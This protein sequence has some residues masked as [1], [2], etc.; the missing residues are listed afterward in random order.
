MKAKKLISTITSFIL[1]ALVITLAAIFIS[2]KMTGGDP[3]FFGYQLK[4]V[5]SGSMEPEFDRGSIIAVKPGGDM[6]RFEKDDIITF[7][8]DEKTYITHRVLEV[9]KDGNQVFY[10]TKGDN[11]EDPDSSHVLSG[12]VV[13]EYTGFTVP[14][15]GY[16]VNFAKSKMGTAA[17]LFIPGILL[18]I[19]A[20]HLINSALSDI[21]NQKK[22]KT[23]Q[24]KIDV[25]NYEDT[26]SELKVERKS[27]TSFRNKNYSGI[28]RGK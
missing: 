18:I 20:I 3:T 6:T 9:K 15:I 4:A 1:I 22:I 19:Y 2:S 23:E 5:L 16:F 21:R 12:Q 10:I 14:Y 26:K 24:L 28:G 7:K 17:V 8:R 25:I 13:A 11:N 27:E